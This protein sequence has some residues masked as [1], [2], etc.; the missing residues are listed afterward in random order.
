MLKLILIAA[1][2]WVLAV[3]AAQAGA[4]EAELTPEQATRIGGDFNA[5]G[6]KLTVLRDSSSKVFKTAPRAGQ[7]L[8]AAFRRVA[9][10]PSTRGFV[11][12]LLF[13]VG[14]YLL[15]ALAV[16]GVR[17]ATASQRHGPRQR[18]TTMRAAPCQLN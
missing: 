8:G 16:F 11:P 13:V 15:F 10:A 2:G 4:V 5:Y 1:V 17:K 7:E 6:E 3:A 14:A 18:R 12:E 9:E